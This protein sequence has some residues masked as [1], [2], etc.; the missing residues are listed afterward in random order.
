MTSDP[1]CRTCEE[2]KPR[3]AFSVHDRS[4]G[5]LRADCKACRA[6]R[7]TRE[8]RER[9]A[10]QGFIHEKEWAERFL[11]NLP[12]AGPDECWEWMGWRAPDGYGR[13]GVAGDRWR[14]HR[15]SFL[16]HHG[17]LPSGAFICHRCDNPPCC[18]PAHLYAGGPATNVQDMVER[19]R[20][21]NLA[22]E[23]SGA[24]RITKEQVRQ[25]RDLA[26]LG[27]YQRDIARRFGISQSQ[28]SNIVTRKHWLT[29][30]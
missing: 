21:V 16:L 20:L 15:L 2:T 14:A 29:V 17:D 30:A 19:N 26:E 9:R 18:N 4:T 6:A 27:V 8:Y 3:D 11:A 23:A 28:V 1:T 22:G 5:R 13:F 10:A 12:D 24:S 7:A 25:I